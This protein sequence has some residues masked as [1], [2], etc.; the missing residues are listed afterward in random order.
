VEHETVPVWQRLPLGLHVLPS[1]QAPQEPALQ[2]FPTSQDL[3]LSADRHVPV[4]QEL[5]TPQ[6]V[7]Q[8]IPEMQCPF[9]Q[10]P[11]PA[12]TPPSA[13][14]GLHVP[15]EQKPDTQ[16]ELAVQLVLHAEV[17]P[18]TRPLGQALVAA[19]Q[20][21]EVPSHALLVNV[22]PEH[23]SA[24]QLVPE[25][26]YRHEPAPSHFPSMPQT[27]PAVQVLWGSARPALT[28]RHCPVVLSAWPFKAAVHALHPAHA[29]WQ[30]TPSAMI[31]DTH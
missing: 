18:Q 10:S 22:D 25:A 5:Q 7:A 4:A 23:V 24:A 26:V 17:E 15:E 2:N 13:T 11:S 20:V 8:Q 14:L 31:P 6:V 29:S 9:W 21:C 28:G 19:A 3:P 30:H 1:G 16:S 12:H 27:G